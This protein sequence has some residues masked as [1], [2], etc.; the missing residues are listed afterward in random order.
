MLKALL[1]V[2][3]VSLLA[4]LVACGFLCRQ[5]RRL[6]VAVR[7]LERLVPPPETL[8]EDYGFSAGVGRTQ[9]Q[10]RVRDVRPGGGLRR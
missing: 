9:L 10:H 6:A 2:C 5:K 3:T 7:E 1:V 8:P 4:A